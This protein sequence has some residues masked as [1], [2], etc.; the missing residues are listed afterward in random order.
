MQ[1]R[2]VAIG[3]RA[4]SKALETNKTLV[5]IHL[6]GCEIDVETVDILS[7]M[8]KNNYTII[9]IE[10]WA[11]GL[12]RNNIIKYCK[13]NELLQWKFIHPIIIDTCIAMY[14]LR[15]PS[16]VLLEIIDWFPYWEIG[17]NRYTKVTLIE[18]VKRSIREMFKKRETNTNKEIK[19]Q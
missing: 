8:L 19:I 1:R 3:I 10:I 6:T 5:S 12:K 16:Y 2:N 9:D 7:E 13:R 4:I 11:S 18:N 15:L 17:V 14:N